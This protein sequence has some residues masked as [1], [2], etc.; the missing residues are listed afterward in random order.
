MANIIADC[1]V[2]IDQIKIVEKGGIFISSGIIRKMVVEKL[3]IKFVLRK[4]S[5]M[6]MG[7]HSVEYI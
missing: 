1:T 6:G 2:L 4:P 5:M 3:K 7:L